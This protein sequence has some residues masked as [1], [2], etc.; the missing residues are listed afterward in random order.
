MHALQRLGTGD[1]PR[2]V[3]HGLRFGRI[4]AL[5]KPNGRVRGL[6]MS[7][8]L[9]RFAARAL[10]QTS[11]PEFETACAPFQFALSTRAGSESLPRVVRAGLD[12]HP[13]LTLVS[14]DGVGA[15]DHVSR[16][17]FAERALAA[18]YAGLLIRP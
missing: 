9:R 6:V 8:V 14:I 18:G 13:S 4:A 10:A 1:I 12:R 17:W 15:F 3:Q 2:S 5:Q 16:E 11:M 7:D